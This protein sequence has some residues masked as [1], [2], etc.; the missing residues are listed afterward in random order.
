MD[1]KPRSTFSVYEVYLKEEKGGGYM[2]DCP[3]LPGCAA[4]GAD[5]AEALTN[6][7]QAI[8]EHL[9][10]MSPLADRKST[11]RFVIVETFE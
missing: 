11:R 10:R 1:R 6:A 2:V 7:K 9:R 4:R 8:V 5:E 3:T